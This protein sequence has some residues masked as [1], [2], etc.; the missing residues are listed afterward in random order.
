M[1]YKSPRT[2]VREYLY[3]EYNIC[4]YNILTEDKFWKTQFTPLNFFN[5]LYRDL[6]FFE[7]NSNNYLEIKRYFG[8]C[9]LKGEKRFLLF[10]SLKEL[11]EH[12]YPQALLNHE[13]VVFK[14]LEYIKKMYAESEDVIGWVNQEDAAEVSNF[15]HFEAIKAH[16]V[17]IPDIKNKITH[18]LEMITL[19]KQ[20]EIGWNNNTPFIRNCTL[21]I[22]KYKELLELKHEMPTT[23]KSAEFASDNQFY[24]MNFKIE[25]LT[26]HKL[27]EYGFDKDTIENLLDAN[28]KPHEH[29]YYRKGQ[30][31]VASSIENKIYSGFAGARK[32]Y[33][34]PNKIEFP[35]KF[36]Q[37]IKEYHELKLFEYLT[38]QKGLMGSLFDEEF[39][40]NIFEDNQTKFATREIEINLAQKAKCKYNYQLPISNEHQ[41][42]IDILQNYI[43]FLNR[44]KI[45]SPQK[46]EMTVITNDN[47][48]NPPPGVDIIGLKEPEAYKK[49]LDLQDEG[50]AKDPL[51]GKQYYNWVIN[52][53][54]LDKENYILAYEKYGLDQEKINNY[55]IQI[56]R[57]ENRLTSIEQLINNR[58]LEN[59]NILNSD[60]ANENNLVKSNN[61]KPKFKPE[62]VN[63]I[64]NILKD[65]FNQ[66]NQV[67]LKKILVS[68]SSVSQKLIFL[69]TGNRLADAFKQLYDAGFITACQKKE[70]EKW[71]SENFL[72]RYRGDIKEYKAKYLND[73]ISTTKDMCQ[74][75]ILNVKS[76]V[77]SKVN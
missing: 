66:E 54:A 15:V 74:K 12:Y 40:K 9:K 2:N 41:R 16:L 22:E 72:F 3:D 59:L 61:A 53:A 23:S 32:Y 20:Q 44:L 47:F 51:F 21:E 39:A 5:L 60:Q 69:D 30:I 77:I 71:I 18:L 64:F 45:S 35:F 56:K 13:P 65:F 68:G 50:L 55:D 14:S 76:G 11:I 62:I 25:D 8:K 7:L 6:E 67:E 33:F 37:L 19:Y 28:S 4:I 73:I 34:R 24:D 29:R 57:A 49:F 52:K 1:I 75:P 36:P 42:N 46:K 10:K 27:K 43:G 70:L 17:T 31:I 63:D 26:E 38:Y 48:T 58:G